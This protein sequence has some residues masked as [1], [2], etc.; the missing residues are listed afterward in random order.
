[1][2]SIIP[3]SSYAC[4]LLLPVSLTLYKWAGDDV[5]MKKSSCRTRVETEATLFTLLQRDF[6]E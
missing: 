2:E 5:L 4:I 6:K 1:M 3:C